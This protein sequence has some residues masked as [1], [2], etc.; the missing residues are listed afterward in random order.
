MPSD[1]PPPVS[2]RFTSNG[3]QKEAALKRLQKDRHY[4][5]V[6]TGKSVRRRNPSQRRPPSSRQVD[7]TTRITTCLCHYCCWIVGLASDLTVVLETMPASRGPR[8]LQQT[9][10]KSPL[11]REGK[12]NKSIANGGCETKSNSCSQPPG[13]PNHQQNQLKSPLKIKGAAAKSVANRGCETKC[14]SGSQPPGPPRLQQNRPKSPINIKG[15]AAKLVANSGSETRSNSGPQHP[16]NH[17]PHN[18]GYVSEPSSFYFTHRGMGSLCMER[19]RR[20]VRLWMESDSETWLVDT[21]FYVPS[22]R[23]SIAPLI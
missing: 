14:N 7:Q 18:G 4:G 12:A 15:A 17:T 23:P 10:P 19:A 2:Y 13:P 3:F 5:V 1:S 9:H 21:K 8:R 6:E 20:R 22:N 11:N 16:Q